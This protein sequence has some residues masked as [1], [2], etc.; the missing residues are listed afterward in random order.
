MGI[1]FCI[2]KFGNTNKKLYLCSMRVLILLL[3]LNFSGYSQKVISTS[4]M[5]SMDSIS[6]TRL[7]IT[8][9]RYEPSFNRVKIRL[10]SIG[11]SNIGLTN[12]VDLLDDI[13]C[14]EYFNIVTYDIRIRYYIN[15]YTSIFG[16][17]SASSIGDI[18][19]VYTIGLKIKF[20]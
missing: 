10:N 20:K 12:E 16:R 8:M 1:V 3:L 15:R 19:K 11:S 4:Y 6:I 7:P 14:E 18:G 5:G 9:G 13:Y 2:I 17:L